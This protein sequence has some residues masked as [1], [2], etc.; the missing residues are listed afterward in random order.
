MATDANGKILLFGGQGPSGNLN[1]TW[2]FDLHVKGPAELLADLGKAVAGVGPGTSLADKVSDAQAAL[3]HNE[4]AGTCSLLRAFIN[5]V[6]AQ[7]GKSIPTDI[8]TSLIA[9]ATHI[10]VLLGC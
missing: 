1:D 10:R 8:A 9:D 4:A 3:A 7:S 2:L 5:E 6:K